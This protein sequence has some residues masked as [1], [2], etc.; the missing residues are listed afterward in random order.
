[1]KLPRH[2]YADLILKHYSSA[3]G[4]TG[5]AIKFNRGSVHELPGDFAVVEFPPGEHRK[6]WTYATCCMS[7]P[8]DEKPIELHIFSPVQTGEVVEILYAAAHYHRTGAR[9]GLGHTVNFGKPWI[10]DSNCEYG[11]ISLPYL[12]GQKLEKL[13]ADN[14]IISFYWLIPITGIERDFKIKH[15]LGKLEELFE[16]VNFNYLDIQRES[17]CQ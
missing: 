17:V 14:R 8:E 7:R 4:A 11:L 6:M 15:G 12:D 10:D 3:W 1:M 9:I 13:S 2:R 5:R 16:K